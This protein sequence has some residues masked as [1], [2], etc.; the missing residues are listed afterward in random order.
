M[1]HARCALSVAFW[2]VFFAVAATAQTPPQ[3]TASPIEKL[4]DNL[5]RV[6]NIRVDTAKREL[7]VTGKVNP[8]TTLEFI[9]NP[10]D[11]MKAYESAITLETNAI[12][13]NAALLLLGLDPSHGRR[14][15][16]RD[17]AVAGDP[18]EVWIDT[19]G[20]SP[21]HLRAERLIYDQDTKD[22]PSDGSWVF[23]GST[24]LPAPDGR[25]RAEADGVLIGFVH[26]LATIIELSRS[27][28]VGRYG[29]VILNPTL[30]LTAGMPV[31]LTVKA[32]GAASKPH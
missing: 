2:V 11:G 16:S 21:Q 10:I 29:A 14:G 26:D 1:K 24:F 28:G 4:S 31:T 19:T 25:Y 6:G 13:F 15:N 5:Y 20:S 3:P 27:Q 18:V 30:G 8:V 22:T 7:A 23:T 12:T 32:V 17:Q 9:A